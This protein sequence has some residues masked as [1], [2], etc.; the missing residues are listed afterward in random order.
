MFRPASG[1][2]GDVRIK[3]QNR[4]QAQGIFSEIKLHSGRFLWS[5][6]QNSWLQIQRSQVRFTALPDFLRSCGSGT[7]STPHEDNWGATLMKSSSCGSGLKKTRFTAD[8]IRCADHATPLYSRKFVLTP[9]TSGSRTIRIV[10]LL[11]V[12]AFRVIRC[13]GSHIGA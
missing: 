1:V 8:G 5:S 13:W 6:G 3:L 2:N 4:A 10:H 9:S 12:D 11:S 7:G